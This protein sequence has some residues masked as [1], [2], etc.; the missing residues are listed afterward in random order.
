MRAYLATPY[1]A[2]PGGAAEALRSTVA[3][4]AAASSRWGLVPVAGLSD[5]RRTVGPVIWS[6]L[7]WGRETAAHLAELGQDRTEDQMLASAI[8]VM[9]DRRHQFTALIRRVPDLGSEGM[10]AEI[11]AANRLG[12]TVIDWHLGAGPAEF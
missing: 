4:M 12:L 2:H 11:E 5:L 8:Q 9:G 10:A 3:I 1:R 6:P 7:L